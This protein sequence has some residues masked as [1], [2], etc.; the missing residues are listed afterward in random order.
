MLVLLVSLVLSQVE[1]ASSEGEPNQAVESPVAATVNGHKIRVY[2]IQRE[3]AISTRGR[4]I[5]KP[6]RPA[7][8][9]S[10][11]HKLVERELV[12]ALLK[13]TKHIAS[14]TEVEQ[15]WDGLKKRLAKRAIPIEK[16][17]KEKGFRNLDHWRHEAR[18][19]LSWSSFLDNY[20]T[21]A[22][23]QKYFERNRRHFDGSEVRA[24]HILW[25]TADPKELALAR[26]KASE[27]RAAILKKE[28]SFA[29]AAK[30]YSQSPTAEDGGDIGFLDRR[31]TMP[32]SFSKAAFDLKAGDVSQPVSTR[33][34]V[35]LIQCTEL[36]PGKSNWTD[37]RDELDHA[38]RRWLFTWAA[39]KLRGN[40]QIVFTGA[41]PHWRKDESGR[42]LIPVAERK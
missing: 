5:A 15:H 8:E 25:K 27:V 9:A 41:S 13:T 21:E 38:V 14:D 16:H 28:I 24:S 40:A 11:L 30:K 20:V 35:H 31:Q 29:A 34:G 12:L 3:L 22:N 36:K 1:T 23:L 26:I 33:F 7:L 42:R 17:F 10:A 4:P 2:D 6:T 19:E 39:D 32:E 37:A 18:W